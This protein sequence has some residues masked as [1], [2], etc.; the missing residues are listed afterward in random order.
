MLKAGV[1]S[2]TPVAEHARRQDSPQSL[3]RFP[4]DA[5]HNADSFSRAFLASWPTEK[6]ALEHEVFQ[7]AFARYFGRQAAR[8]TGLGKCV[9]WISGLCASCLSV[10]G[11]HGGSM[12]CS[13]HCILKGLSSTGFTPLA[14]W[15]R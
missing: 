13:F 15:S 7:F 12:T 4:Y 8:G 6:A 10:S 14:E 1:R 9:Q 11:T 5:F 3:A 2:L